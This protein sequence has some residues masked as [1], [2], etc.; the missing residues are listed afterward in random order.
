MKV[1]AFCRGKSLFKY[2]PRHQLSE[3]FQTRVRR[4][5]MAW[6]IWFR[7]KLCLGANIASNNLIQGSGDKKRKIRMSSIILIPNSATL[8]TQ[9]RIDSNTD[10]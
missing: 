10:L 7:I 5:S 6:E 4:K 8:G 9:A 1:I 3:R 2:K